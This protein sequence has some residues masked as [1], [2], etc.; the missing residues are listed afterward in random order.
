VTKKDLR[1]LRILHV[2]DE[3]NDAI[4][5]LKACERAKVPLQWHWSSSAEDA[6]AYLLGLDKYFD[7]AAYPLPQILVLDLKLRGSSGFEFL[8]WLRAQGSFMTLPVLIFTASLSREDKTRAMALG[9]S[10]YFLKPTSF[11]ALVQMVESLNI[12]G[13]RAN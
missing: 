11:A 5:L 9:A 10:C 2:E 13:L 7:R 4:L 1:P 12:D 6:K 8:T 3:E